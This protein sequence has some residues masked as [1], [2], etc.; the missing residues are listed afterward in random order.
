MSSSIPHLAL[1]VAVKDTL[2]RKLTT[3]VTEQVS[4]TTSLPEHQVGNCW[5]CPFSGSASG[6]QGPI[7]FR[8][9]KRGSACRSVVSMEY[10][11][12]IEL[13]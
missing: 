5:G 6:N 3:P 1:K 10:E 13:F 2:I 12:A 11:T 9:A 8:V 4:I 7:S